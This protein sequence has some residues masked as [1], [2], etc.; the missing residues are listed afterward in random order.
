MFQV[1]GPTDAGKSSLCKI[2]VNYAV[3]MGSVPTLVDLDIGTSPVLYTSLPFSP[4][5]RS[6]V[7]PVPAAWHYPVK[8]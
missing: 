1:V 6:T 7:L 8:R 2:L 3:R 4:L 5:N